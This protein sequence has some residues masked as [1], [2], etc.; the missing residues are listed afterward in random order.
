MGNYNPNLPVILGQEW[1]P[2]RDEDITYSPNVN[3]VERGVGFSLLTPRQASYGAYY[4]HALPA[5]DSTSQAT[6][7]AVYDEGTEALS[8]PIESVIIPISSAATTGSGIQTFGFTATQCLAFPDDN[9]IV[10]EYNGGTPQSLAMFFAVPDYAQLL[11]GKRILNVGLVY[12]GAGRIQNGLGT[13]FINPTPTVSTTLLT[14]KNNSGTDIDYLRFF[15][16]NMGSLY[17]LNTLVSPAA[18][19]AE[20]SYGEV[21]LGD[22]NVWYDNTLSPT[23]GLI[24]PWRFEELLRFGSAPTDRQFLHL[25]V[26]VPDLDGGSSNSQVW[27]D[28]A[29]LKVTYCTETRLA[30]GGRY[31][32]SRYGIN[33]VPMRNVALSANPVLSAGDYVYT[34]SMPNP[35]DI[36]FGQGSSAP[37]PDFNGLRE[38]YSIDSQYGVQVNV[39]FPLDDHLGETF[40]SE[41]TS[42]L[43]QL[44]LHTS[45]GAILTDTHVYGRQ[46]AAEV[47]GIR[48]A[49][50]ELLDTPIGISTSFPW[51]R[52]YARR[53]GETTV[54]LTLTG[55]GGLSG[56]TASITPD[57]FDELDEVL[58]GWKEV[59]LQFDTPPSMGTAGTPNWRF[60]ATGELAGNR[61]EV[62]GASAPALSG[63][64]GNLY[65]L[66]PAAWQLYTGTY[67]AP[68][69]A[70]QD[71]EWIPQG[72]G[73]PPISGVGVSDDSSDLFLIFAQEPPGVSGFGVETL[74]QPVTGIGQ[75]CDVDPCCI[76]T[77]ISF[78]QLT[79]DATL[80]SQPGDPWFYEIQRSD[81][82]DTDWQTI[83]LTPLEDSGYMLL[84]GNAGTY[85]ST[86]D[87]AAL[88]ITGDI[89]VSIDVALD[90]WTPSGRQVLTGKWVTTG[91]QGSWFL[92]V[93]TSGLLKFRATPDGTVG[94]SEDYDS[95]I[96]PNV[97]DGGR[98]SLRVTLDINNGAGS[99]VATFYTAD[100]S[101]LSPQGW[102]QL[103]ST[104]TAGVLA[105]IFN[106]T[107]PLEVGSMDAG[108][109]GNL[110][111]KVY[112]VEVRNGITNGTLVAAP[113]FDQQVSGTTSFV[114]ST[115]RTWTL[116]GDAE[117]VEGTPTS[118]NDFEA[119]V[120]IITS[121]RIRAI[122]E[123]GFYGPWS[124]EVTA[125]LTEPGVTIGCDGG[126]L[127]IFT[128]NERQDGSIN[129]AY[130]SV[131]WDQQVTEDFAFP[132][133]NF[134]I[135]QPMYNRDFFT[136]FSPL[137]RGGE[138]FSRTVLVQAAAISL[139]TLGD[140]RSL[141]DMAWEAVNYICVRDEEGN[142]WFATIGVP[143]GRV[144]NNRRLYLAPVQVAEV[145]DTPTPVNLTA[146][147]VAG[148]V[149]TEA[150]A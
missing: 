34:L 139:P 26:Q 62:L 4:T 117:L 146:D 30:Y 68:T 33:V 103:G 66:A 43:P 93:E 83:M 116:Q 145:T 114:D 53:F 3:N 126:H 118:F 8:G 102:T 25:L 20:Y 24:Y 142:R 108:T 75:E 79:W 1:V 12:S 87:A 9:P 135:L 51:V 69:G 104:D 88:D 64:P 37:S 7:L 149:D 19:T 55:Q 57:E 35:G 100:N 48:Y 112:S 58:D 52:F 76:P 106:S 18:G 105:G 133:A 128:S 45:G 46:V 107:A 28:Y 131:W 138:Q 98:L 123:Y 150:C 77:A 71:L 23:A 143:S 38:A 13:E 67:L 22:A 80:G 29:A 50:Q 59:T 27:L 36:S 60:T 49:Q 74:C 78:N 137:E 82:V 11:A 89:D 129:L 92:S 119:R 40:T 31:G 125:T 91:N 134:K 81:E 136:A 94:S 42:I 21:N 10:F 99:S 14:R 56:S 96:A 122:D 111:G 17:Q 130:S 47:W 110:A 86:P 144:V 72:L 73:S 65:N 95:S 61:W 115:G 90:D 109:S 140:F 41:P 84:D 124:S 63:I 32:A 85:A 147:S 15:A 132:E 16:A 121:Y 70:T 120:G 127:L 101:S 44:S 148:V 6:M 2:I 97:D 141:R 5:E 39:P 113:R 54:P